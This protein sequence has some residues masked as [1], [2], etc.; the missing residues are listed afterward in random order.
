MFESSLGMW[1]PLVAIFATTYL[2]GLIAGRKGIEP[3][4]RVQR[5]KGGG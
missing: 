4:A 3:L 2:V 1:I 5:V